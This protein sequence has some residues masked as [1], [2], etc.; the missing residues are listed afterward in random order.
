MDVTGLVIGIVG[1]YSTCQSCYNLYTDVRDAETSAVT[2]AHELEIHKSILKAWG[3]YWQIQPTLSAEERDGEVSEKL[4]RYLTRYPDK[5]IGIA[6]A[7]HCI[8]E[9]LSDKRKLLDTYGLEVNLEV[10]QGVGFLRR[11]FYLLS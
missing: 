2:A 5:A 3:F 9:A 10:V 6:S 7:L 8:G 11:W 4:K 1:L